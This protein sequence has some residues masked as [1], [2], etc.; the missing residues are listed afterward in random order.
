MFA[1]AKAFHQKV[2]NWNVG[3]VQHMK[4]MLTH[5]DAFNQEIGGWQVGKVEDMQYM[6]GT[7]GY[8]MSS[9]NGIWRIARRRPTDARCRKGAR[10]LAVLDVRRLLEVHFG[11][12]LTAPSRWIV[13]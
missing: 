13:A 8:G 2:G 10:K 12:A 7:C 5:A 4:H 9:R 11:D 3:T 1:Y 6:W